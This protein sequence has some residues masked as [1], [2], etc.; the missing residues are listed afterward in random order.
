MLSAS[1]EIGNVPGLRLSLL[2]ELAAAEGAHAL[3]GGGEG[4]ADAV[5]IGCRG[6][7]AGEVRCVCAI[8][9]VVGIVIREGVGWRLG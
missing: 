8:V 7:V 4:E 2:A 5:G 3:R 9:D 6:G 1:L